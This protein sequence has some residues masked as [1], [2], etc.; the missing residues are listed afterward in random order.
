MPGFMFFNEFIEFRAFF[1][2][3]A[4]GLV[5]EEARAFQRLT[6]ANNAAT[7]LSVSCN[8]RVIFSNRTNLITVFA[9]YQTKRIVL[10]DGVSNECI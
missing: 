3:Y 9:G 1:R 10:V 6:I 8:D 5:S 4:I 2:F 7:R